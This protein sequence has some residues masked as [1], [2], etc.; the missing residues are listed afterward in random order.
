[1]NWKSW[2]LWTATAIATLPVVSMVLWYQVAMTPVQQLEP[3]FFYTALCTT[4]VAAFG[5]LVGVTW[6]VAGLV[7]LL[8]NRSRARPRA[9]VSPGA[10]GPG[11]PAAG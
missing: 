10:S 3:W 5:V 7:D 9:S 4:I 2:K 6:A 1:M 11:P 8:R